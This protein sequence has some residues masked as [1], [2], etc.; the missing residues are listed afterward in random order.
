MAHGS[1]AHHT[2]AEARTALKLRIAVS[3]AVACSLAIVLADADRIGVLIQIR[4]FPGESSW[5]V[6]YGPHPALTLALVAVTQLLA[7]ALVWLAPP[8]AAAGWLALTLS[9]SAGGYAGMMFP[10]THQ[11]VD[12]PL[13]ATLLRWIRAAE[14][15]SADRV[16]R[17]DVTRRLMNA[18]EF[19][20]WLGSWALA[21]GVQLI[22]LK[23]LVTGTRRALPPSEL[24]SNLAAVLIGWIVFM[25]SVAMAIAPFQPQVSTLALAP[26]MR[27][28]GGC[29]GLAGL[30]VWYLS[31]RRQVMVVGRWQLAL[32]P[33][34]MTG[35]LAVLALVQSLSWVA[36]EFAGLLAVIPAIVVL[37]RL[38]CV[39]SGLFFL[40][41]GAL[42]AADSLTR[43]DGVVGIIVAVLAWAGLAMFAGMLYV[44]RGVR[45]L[46]SAGR[47]QA[48]VL[49]T[50]FAAGSLLALAGYGVFAAGAG[51]CQPD[52]T[53]LLC[54]LYRYQDWWL[55]LP[56]AVILVFSILA[57]FFP[58][59]I[60]ARRMFR[61]VTL[62]TAVTVVMIFLFGI[63]ESVVSELLA[64]RYSEGTPRAIAIGTLAVAIHPV[65]KVCDHWVERLLGF[66]LHV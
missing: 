43:G 13:F 36:A 49:L 24:G 58:G 47:S 48:L 11:G 62:Y 14:P 3:I 38:E 17:G 27:V 65:R 8:S 20:P 9:L 61:R 25:T 29:L 1:I 45:R 18:L 52:S 12:D 63:A 19:L 66:L 26:W 21:A 37:V 22:F 32:E 53:T 2:R 34:A 7:L 6:H 42:L 51:R 55:V 44:A 5:A 50:G 4:D 64:A 23:S 10:I 59:R 40:P 15:G 56:L 31:R 54:M 28:I 35:L 60:D 41:F 30:G 33:A 46:E 16:L 39:H 57:L